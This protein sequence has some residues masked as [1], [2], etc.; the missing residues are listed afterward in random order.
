MFWDNARKFNFSKH[1]HKIDD[2]DY[3]WNELSY[4]G[5][6]KVIKNHLNK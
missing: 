6:L 3:W 4:Y 2:A 5:R 1:I